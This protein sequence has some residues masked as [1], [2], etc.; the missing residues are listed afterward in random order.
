MRKQKLSLL[1]AGL[2]LFLVTSV[3]AETMAVIVNLN[4]PHNEVTLTQL[5]Q[6]FKKK[7]T[8]WNYGI[9][10]VPLNREFGSEIRETFSQIVHKKGAKE[11]KEYWLEERYKGATA[12]QELNS[13]EAVKKMVAIKVQAIGYIYLKEV[14]NTVKVLKMGGLS[15]SDAGY[16]LK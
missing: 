9:E 16:K 15:P 7:L 5:D 6:I 14:D 11:M 8:K 10:I 13:S 4:N 2:S 1:L 12:P 3:L